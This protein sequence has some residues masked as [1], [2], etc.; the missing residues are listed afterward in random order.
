MIQR[1]GRS[2]YRVA[3]VWI[4]RPTRSAVTKLF[5]SHASEDKDDFVRPLADTLRKDFEVWFDEYTLKLGDSLRSSIDAGLQSC[6]FGVVV[7]SPAFFTKKWTVSELNGLMALEDANRKLILPIW[8]NVD[9]QRVRNFSPMLAD[10][11]AVSAAAGLERV[12]EEIKIA[13]GASTRTQEIFA[14][15]PAKRALADAMAAVSSRELDE[16]LLR[17]EAGVGLFRAAKIRIEALVWDRLEIA[18]LGSGRRFS[19]S[20]NAED[21]LVDAPGGVRLGISVRNLFGNSVRDAVLRA[22]VG[23]EPSD[24]EE[25]EAGRIVE[26][27]EWKVTCVNSERIGF[28]RGP[29][30]PVESEEDVARLIVLKLSEA[31][32]RRIAERTGDS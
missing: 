9:A 25:A 17:S 31:I 6:D 1:S 8:L 4:A 24:F 20:R 13:V 16:H 18:N 3:R 32:I 15:D 30:K 12:V 27:L 22:A 11:R 19:L 28:R 14:P 23:I 7:L 29:G 5:I 26:D 10:R 21:F 2:I